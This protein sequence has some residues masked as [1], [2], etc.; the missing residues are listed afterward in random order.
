MT[1]EQAH[2]AGVA[3][4]ELQRVTDTGERRAILRRLLR[5]VPQGIRLGLLLK[6][7]PVS[8][9]TLLSDLRAID[10]V[11][12]GTTPRTLWFAPESK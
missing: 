11:K 6:V 1:P 9:M 7:Y 12:R 5:N 4:D 3:Y 10:A 2:A 8:K